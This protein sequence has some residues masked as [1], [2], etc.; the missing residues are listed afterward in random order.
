MHYMYAQ[1]TAVHCSC[2][3]YEYITYTWLKHVRPSTKTRDI[4]GAQSMH[5]GSYADNVTNICECTL[6]M[7][8]IKLCK[9]NQAAQCLFVTGTDTK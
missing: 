8:C 2:I 4:K 1:C 6:A 7:L 3:M 5:R 9:L